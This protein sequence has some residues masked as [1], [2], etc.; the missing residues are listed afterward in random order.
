[1][2]PV[3]F[4]NALVTNACHTA[5]DAALHLD[6]AHCTVRE[7]LITGRTPL[8]RIDPP[9][10]GGFIRGAMRL[11]RTQ[12]GITRVVYIADFRGARL[13]WETSVPCAQAV[14]A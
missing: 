7:I 10:A 3:A 12:G 14:S 4:C 9:P 1:M 5:A 2:K 8:I 6:A 11:R 13:E